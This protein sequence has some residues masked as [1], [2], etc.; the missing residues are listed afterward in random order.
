MDLKPTLILMHQFV[1]LPLMVYVAACHLNNKPVI[2]AHMNR[3]AFAGLICMCAF[4]QNNYE[5]LN[6]LSLD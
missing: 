3:I 5:P 6:N 2:D 4:A 1:H